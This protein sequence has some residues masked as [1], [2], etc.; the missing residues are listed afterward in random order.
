MTVRIFLLIVSFFILISNTHSNDCVKMAIFPFK[1]NAQKKSEVLRG[2]IHDMLKSRISQTG[3]K[4]IIASEKINELIS[5]SI[6][7]TSDK[8]KYFGKLLDADYVIFGSISKFGS[9]FSL[10]ATMLNLKSLQEPLIFAAQVHKEDEV[11]P[12]IDSL[13][14]K[15]N[16]N[17]TKVFNSSA[18]NN[19]NKNKLTILSNTE[20]SISITHE[21][22]ALSESTKK[23]EFIPD[24]DK[25]FSKVQ[26]LDHYIKG[27]HYADIDL[28]G[29]Q[30]VMLIDNSKVY[31][32]KYLNNQLNLLGK[33]ISSSMKLLTI[34]AADLDNNNRSEIYITAFSELS[35]RL[36]SLVLEWNKNGFQ[37]L[38]KNENWY[39]RIIETSDLN[40]TL[41]GQKQGVNELFS[42][43]IYELAWENNVLTQKK[44]LDT[45]SDINFSSF[46]KGKI[47]SEEP[48]YVSITDSNKLNV[49]D[50]SGNTLW[51]GEE[52]YCESLNSITLKISNRNDRISK[53][54]YINQ[55]L[56]LKDLDNNNKFEII[57][58]K[59]N[60]SPGGRIL[61]RFRNY[62]SG[63]ICALEWNGIALEP[64][65]STNKISGYISDY[66]I[67]DFNGDG[68]NELVIAVILSQGFLKKNKSTVI[69]YP[70]DNQL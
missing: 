2:I 51:S 54:R 27:I 19:I 26:N 14:I 47:I 35:N 5:D 41:I 59:Q 9:S 30:E 37:V 28:D 50:K 11:I 48:T 38:K 63:I 43:G 69:Y 53:F 65:W 36:V 7:E 18:E 55:R 58:V 60:A 33:F 40:Q 25:E 29:K 62:K 21:N 52:Y 66:A 6:V 16:K 13:A 20:N 61:E 12:L 23:I 49:Y 17:L 56:L 4:Q 8:A 45:P 24:L 1:V 44:M 67:F 57:V 46:N 68:K 15:I 31:V 70:L 32:Y 22:K 39:F 3:K 34:D 42:K 64:K 10:D